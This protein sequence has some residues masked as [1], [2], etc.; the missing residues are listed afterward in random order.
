MSVS[1]VM[2]YALRDPCDLSADRR[3]GVEVLMDDLQ[4]PTDEFSYG[5][6]KIFIRNPRTVNGTKSEFFFLGVAAADVGSAVSSSP[7]SFSQS[8]CLP[9]RVGCTSCR[10]LSN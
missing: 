6:S 2:K 9:S 4:V 7:L 8:R 1:N 5:R 3:Q 10:R